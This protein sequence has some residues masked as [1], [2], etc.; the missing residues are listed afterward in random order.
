MRSNK[1]HE[2]L[3]VSVLKRFYFISLAFLAFTATA[4]PQ[5]NV[6][7]K[8][9]GIMAD[10]TQTQ[11]GRPVLISF[12]YQGTPGAN[13]VVSYTEYGD[14]SNSRP[15]TKFQINNR[16]VD[17]KE[18]CFPMERS[19]RALHYTIEEHSVLQYFHTQMETGFTV[20]LQNNI[21]VWVA[22]YNQPRP[23]NLPLW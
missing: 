4:S 3:Q 9:N 12:A 15:I 19:I 1:I 20:V 5:Y 14:C 7:Y 11:D 16:S 23:G 6:W 2:C 18:K 22:N 17:A 8:H 13:M 21:R 10:A